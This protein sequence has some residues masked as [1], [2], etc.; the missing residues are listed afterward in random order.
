[1]K[2]IDLLGQQLKSN[3]V[4]DVLECDDLDVIYSFDRLHENQPDEYWV[5]SKAEG[6]QMRFNEDQTLDTLFF[7]IAADEGFSPCVPDS[8]GVPIFD[9]RDSARDYAGQSGLSVTE[10]EVDFLGAFRKWIKIDF[11]S[12]LHHSEFREDKLHGMS[13]FLPPKAQQDEDDQATAAPESKP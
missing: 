2:Y 13:A 4:I 12:H 3:D 5:A 9:S 7:Y 8:L 10:G 6:I 1:M 11:G